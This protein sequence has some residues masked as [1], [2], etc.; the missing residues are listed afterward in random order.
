M[1]RLGSG[2]RRGV[3]ALV[4]FAMSACSAQYFNHGYIPREEDLA[5][6][7]VGESTQEDVARAVGRPSSTGL[8]TGGAWYYVGSRFK[9]VGPKEPQEI[10]RQV[11]SVSFD[12]KGVV[13]NVERFG[14]EKGQVVVL[15]RR[16][17]DSN[18]K[19]LGFLRQLL[20]NI[21]NLNAAQLLNRN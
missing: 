16:V 11:V 18:I 13:E 17:T 2:V 15:S 7:T 14:L 5:K 20:G 4:L 10:D 12:D 9:H 3:I 6:V 8:L 19:G 21:G 1:G